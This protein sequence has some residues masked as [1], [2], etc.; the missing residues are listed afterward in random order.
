MHAADSQTVMPVFGSWREGTRPFGLT[1]VYGSCFM[2]GKSSS[3]V[4]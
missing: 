3:S 2:E 1:D 4:S